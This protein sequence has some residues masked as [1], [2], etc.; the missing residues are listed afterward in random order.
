MCVYIHTQNL[1]SVHFH[2]FLRIINSVKGR[3]QLLNYLWISV[4]LLQKQS[5]MSLH[6]TNCCNE[7]NIID[8]LSIRKILLSQ[9]LDVYSLDMPRITFIYN[10]R[11]Y[12]IMPFMK[13]VNILLLFT[14]FVWQ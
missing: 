14:K 7:C 8:L 9:L 11:W 5:V 1:L 12:F 4:S 13:E 6:L 2:Q 3:S 10:F